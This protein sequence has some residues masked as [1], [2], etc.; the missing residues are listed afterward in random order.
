MPWS[1]VSYRATLLLAAALLIGCA[2]NAPRPAVERVAILP[3][4]NLTSDP[5]LDWASRAI[6]AVVAAECTGVPRLQVLRADSDRTV[7]GLRPTQILH[8][9]L[10][11]VNGKV[12]LKSVLFDA[13]S[14][15]STRS[16]SLSSPD[17]LQLADAL[18]RQFAPQPRP[19][20]TRNL[21]AL[22]WF[23][24]AL[25]EHG[26]AAREGFE[27]AIAADPSFG[28]AYVL[29]AQQH[30]QDGN[31]PALSQTLAG[32]KT[33]K[34]PEVE[35][36]ELD[37]LAAQAVGNQSETV[38][39]L[40]KLAELEP[41]DGES[42]RRVA[43]NA[44][45]IKQ[46]PLAIEWYKKAIASDPENG[47]Y[48]NSL[49]YAQAYL[50]DYEA[51]TASMAEYRKRTPGANPL[52]SLGEIYFMAGRFAEAEKAFQDA[53]QKEPAFQA[54]IDLYKAA[55]ARLMTGDVAG[56]DA[57]FS[58]YLELFPTDPLLDLKKANWDYL[59]GRRKEAV[60]EMQK[61]A[62]GDPKTVVESE[63]AA[64][65]LSQA[66]IWLLQMGR[67]EEAKPF[68]Q[69]AIQTPANA[70]TAA[71]A[72]VAAYLSAPDASPAEWMDRANKMFA[73]PQLGQV[74]VLAFSIA[75]LWGGHFAESVDNLQRVYIQSN[76][77]NWDQPRMLLGW[78]LRETGKTR[79]AEDLFRNY[80]LPPVLAD[81]PFACIIFP[82]VLEWKGRADV[83]RKLAGQ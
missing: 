75:L 47:P 49:G 38:K 62:T 76:P 15:R 14:M 18:A 44:L 12:T 73:A 16:F 60:E 43:D 67:K 83:Y 72:G 10:T 70:A 65:A 3:V 80:P 54:G 41:S 71:V 9:F 26:T 37:V 7:G 63:R 34:V 5:S 66:A 4:E 24:K 64:R 39:A 17:F 77:G 53:F 22:E 68:A 28:L 33:A 31:K 11:L 42:A 40:G 69:K 35:R 58:R 25:A 32:A 78:A 30:I 61:I 74:K 52:D 6:P 45:A 29:L 21:Q 2:G 51:A 20:P 57:L 23:G 8:S 27:K 81:N 56:A 55:F 36:A 59:A 79:E 13:F 82:R 19:A 46:L 1:R 50:G 48:Y